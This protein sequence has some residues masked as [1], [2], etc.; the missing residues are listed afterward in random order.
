MKNLIK[1]DQKIMKNQKFRT[2]LSRIYYGFWGLNI[3][4]LGVVNLD[5]R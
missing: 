2:D 4:F 3:D 5:S 1:I